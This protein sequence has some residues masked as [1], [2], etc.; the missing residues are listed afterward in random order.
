VNTVKNIEFYKIPG[1]YRVAEE[2]LASTG[3][4][5]LNGIRHFVTSTG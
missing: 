1:I 2:L 5:L 4:T 3:W